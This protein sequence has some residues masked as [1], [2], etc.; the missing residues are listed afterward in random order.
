MR[1]FFTS[2]IVESHPFLVLLVAMEMM[3]LFWSGEE[4]QMK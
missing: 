4:N 2:E 3:S 1:F